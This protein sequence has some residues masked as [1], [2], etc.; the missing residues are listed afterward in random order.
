[1]FGLLFGET[2]FSIQYVFFSVVLKMKD[3]KYRKIKEK[4]RDK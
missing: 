3:I 2:K 4:K 1:M